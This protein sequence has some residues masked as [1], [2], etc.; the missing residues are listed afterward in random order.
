M[1]KDLGRIN[2]KTQLIG[3]LATPIGHSLSP[4]MHNLAFK[5]LGLNYAYLAF[6]VGNE[7]LEDVVTGMRA[8]GVRGFNVSMPNKMKIIPYLDQ[9]ADSA[10]FSGAVNTVVNDNGTLT[11]HSTDGMGYVRNLKEHGVDIAGKKMTLIGSG[12][13]ATPIAIQSALEGLAE[14]SIFARND[15]FFEKAVENVRIIN[16]D[17][18]DSN[19]KA[20]VYPL[21]DQETLRAEIASSDI[22]ANGTGVGMKPF[23]GLSVIEDVSMLRPDLIV[24]DVVYNPVKSK[25]LEQAEEAGCKTI[26]GLGMM[27]W[28]GAMAFELWTGKEMPVAYIN[29]Q[30]FE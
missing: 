18:K 21:E 8:L 12:G 22:L 17:M 6:E 27:V 5:K 20:N 1:T 29:E 3:L 28:Q 14:I 23:E 9:L 7:Q 26:N 13:A 16:E 4:T 30:M 2:G 25:L 15:A 10:K 24:S 19:C 11:G